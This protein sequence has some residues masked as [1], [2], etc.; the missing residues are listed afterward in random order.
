MYF[1]GLTD[2]NVNCTRK[3]DQFPCIEKLE[4]EL[5]SDC[6]KNSSDSIFKLYNFVF[7]CIPFTAY[8]AIVCHGN[9]NELANTSISMAK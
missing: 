2:I 7:K 9:K 4:T 3:Y 1:S 6:H 5:H 8:T